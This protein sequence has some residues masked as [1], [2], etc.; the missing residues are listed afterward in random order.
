MANIQPPPFRGSDYILKGGVGIFTDYIITQS[1]YCSDS[2]TF[3]L[4]GCAFVRAEKGHDFDPGSKKSKFHYNK[5]I[6]NSLLL[7]S[8]SHSM[9][10]L[11][12]YDKAKWGVV[13][14]VNLWFLCPWAHQLLSFLQFSKF[15]GY[16]MSDIDFILKAGINLRC[17]PGR[18]VVRWQGKEWCR[19]GSTGLLAQDL[20]TF[21]VNKPNGSTD[22]SSTDS[23]QVWNR[24][25]L[26]RSF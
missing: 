12:R 26:L 25:F 6:E 4:C 15:S 17:A 10:I 20:Q 18:D 9:P 14:V 24:L 8:T 11:A 23:P 16:F 19:S 1:C 13:V 22:N 2:K 21:L 5:P 3:L 7:N